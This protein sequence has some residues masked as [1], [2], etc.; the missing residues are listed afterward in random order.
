MPKSVPEEISSAAVRWVPPRSG[1]KTKIRSRFSSLR[2]TWPCKNGE[3]Y[4]RPEDPSRYDRGVAKSRFLRSRLTDEALLAYAGERT[5]ERGVAY[6]QAGNVRDIRQKGDRISAIVQGTE[7]YE[8]S[9]KATAES[10]VLSCTCPVGQGGAFCKHGVAVGLEWLRQGAVDGIEKHDAMRIYLESLDKAA[11][12][13]LLLEHADGDSELRRKLEIKSAAA[14]KNTSHLK[15][16]IDRALKS[17]RFIDYY[18]MPTYAQ[19]A[20]EVIDQIETVLTDGDGEGAIELCEHALRAVEHTL[21]LCDDSDGHMSEILR[22]LQ[23]IHLEACHE[24]RPDPVA[25]ARRLFD[26]ELKSDWEV[27]YQAAQTYAEVLGDSGL[28]EYRKLATALWSVM[29]DL[30]AGDKV[31]HD[32]H[33]FRITSMMQALAEASGDLEE[34]ANI[35]KKDLS[36]P[37]GYLRL[38]QIYG[39]MERPDL[40]IECVQ[41]GIDAF[42]GR[43]DERLYEDLA[44]RHEEVGDDYRSMEVAWA[45]FSTNPGFRLYPALKERATRLD[46]WERWRPKAFEAIRKAISNRKASH[47]TTYYRSDHSDLVSAY[48]LDGDIESAWREAQEGGCSNSL[49]LE[50]ALKRQAHHPQDSIPIYK[51]YAETMVQAANNKS[52]EIAVA[53]VARIRGIASEAEFAEFAASLRTR[54]K[55]KRNFIKLMDTESA[56][57]NRSPQ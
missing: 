2:V 32:S 17:H 54:H 30:G 20:A 43:P 39:R 53:Y 38:A 27:F 10:L 45:L 56:R 36:S 46:Q 26:W 44:D 14:T 22:R 42:P 15:K 40:A 3:F 8:T 52:Y 37:Y 12:V 7:D 31:S 23:D 29:P 50:V 21:D 16:T 28:A 5:Y 24:S 41:R 49:L 4:G 34:L 51:A 25:L 11:L 9:I 1:S 18:R 6:R 48:L 55:A 19:A 35:Q 47:G 57:P 13:K 33:R